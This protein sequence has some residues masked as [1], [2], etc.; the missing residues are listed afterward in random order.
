MV[1]LI[2]LAIF[3][4]CGEKE[5]APKPEEK[6]SDQAP[7]NKEKLTLKGLSVEWLDRDAETFVKALQEGNSSGLNV[8]NLSIQEGESFQI[9]KELWGAAKSAK[10]T[11]HKLI[12]KDMFYWVE[13]EKN[14]GEKVNIR[15]RYSVLDGL[16]VKISKI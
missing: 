12:F 14:T 13:I 5:N 4:S 15:I 11:K 1:C 16:P 3:C 6:S 2:A 8:D 7:Q 9:A 10:I